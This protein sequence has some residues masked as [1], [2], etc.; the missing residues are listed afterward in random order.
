MQELPTSRAQVDSLTMRTSN[1]LPPPRQ[2]AQLLSRDTPRSTPA[3]C[4]QRCLVASQDVLS[5]DVLACTTQ[6]VMQSWCRTTSSCLPALQHHHECG[7]LLAGI[8]GR[9]ANPT[10]RLCQGAKAGSVA[11]QLSGSRSLEPAPAPRC[12][13][14]TPGH[15]QHTGAGTLMAAWARSLRQTSR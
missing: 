15:C 4:G 8:P 1:M 12:L 5:R 9:S 7:M 10:V 13:F 3:R 14:W 6:M 2:A 11:D